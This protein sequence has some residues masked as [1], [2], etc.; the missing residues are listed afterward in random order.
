MCKEDVLILA[1]ASRRRK[2]LLE[3]LGLPF[4][5]IPSR[6]V[7][8]VEEAEGP[9]EHVLRLCELKAREVGESYRDRWIIGADTIVMIDGL[10]LGKPRNRKEARW[11]LGSLQGRTHEVHTGICVLRLADERMSKR[12]VRTRVRF[13]PLSEDE[14]DWYIRTG[15]PFD[16]AGGYAIQGYGSVLVRSIHGSY[17]NVVGLPLTELVEMLRRLGAWDLFSRP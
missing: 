4:V 16:K 13:R 14:I 11:M 15:E 12:A 8:T 2:E 10:I 5:C 9:R 6:V 17:T 1:S 3:K 7:E